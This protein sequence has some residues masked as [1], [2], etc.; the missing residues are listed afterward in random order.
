M[1]RFR[2]LPYT[3]NK[4]RN[5]CDNNRLKEVLWKG[6]IKSFSEK[7]GK[8]F[9]T[10]FWT[11][12]LR[13]ELETQTQINICILLLMF[14]IHLHWLWSQWKNKCLIYKTLNKQYMTPIFSVDVS[15]AFYIK[16]KFSWQCSQ[17]FWSRLKLPDNCDN[18]RYI[19]KGK[20]IKLKVI[21]PLSR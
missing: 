7:L 21:F 11:E 8:F 17:I 1:I 14:S 19:F 12:N 10:K 2:N 16:N 15:P 18:Y 6:A 13:P 5:N 4:G 3:L 9:L 20:E